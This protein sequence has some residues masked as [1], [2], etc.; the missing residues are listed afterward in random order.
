MTSPVIQR[1]FIF[2]FIPRH[3]N[4]KASNAQ[5]ITITNF[6]NWIRIEIVKRI[7]AVS[8]EKIC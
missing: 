1:I 2:D 3:N 8:K 5:K 7:I 6:S 4:I